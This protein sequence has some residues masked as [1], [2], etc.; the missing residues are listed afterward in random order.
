MARP[1]QSPRHAAQ[2]YQLPPRGPGIPTHN[3]T[4]ERRARARPPLPQDRANGTAGAAPGPQ[5]RRRGAAEAASL[6]TWTLLCHKL[7]E[8]SC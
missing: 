8:Y 2:D 3:L 1:K 5:P 4:R 7:F 6:L